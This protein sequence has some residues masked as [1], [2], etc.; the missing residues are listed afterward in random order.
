M[1][2]ATEILSLP[3]RDIKE[4]ECRGKA[5]NILF[6][7]KQGQYY[8]ELDKSCLG[9]A[10]VLA[11]ESIASIGESFILIEKESDIKRVLSADEALCANLRK[12]YV[13]LGVEVISET[14]CHLGK[15]IDFVIDRSGV[16]SCII[17]DNEAS[18]DKADIITVCEDVVF[19]KASGDH[20]EGGKMAK[21]NTKDADFIGEDEA[22]E[23][24]QKSP[25][26]LTVREDVSSADGAFEIKAGSVIT[27]E[28]FNRA[29]EHDAVLAL[30][31]VAM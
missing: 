19:V 27:E 17:L 14:G 8:L 10:E 25:V 28:I 3:I 12:S 16:L 21:E 13:L 18:I 11:K 20:D 6:G 26:G 7:A 4:G 9:Q 30:G 1:Y 2:K 23:D 5:R 24:N 15:I 22:K 29:K 31:F